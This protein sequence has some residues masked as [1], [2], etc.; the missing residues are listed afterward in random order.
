[1]YAEEIR[2]GVIDQVA[3]CIGDRG[4]PA[5]ASVHW[6]PALEAAPWDEARRQLYEVGLGARLNH[7]GEHI[8]RTR[9]VRHEDV[10]HDK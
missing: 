10:Q 6:E 8:A 2:E 1:M 7:Y 9:A 3:R 5:L 4:V